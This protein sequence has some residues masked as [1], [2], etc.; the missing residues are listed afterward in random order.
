MALDKIKL[1]KCPPTCNQKHTCKPGLVYT[2][3]RLVPSSLLYNLHP[4]DQLLPE[5]LQNLRDNLNL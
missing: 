5:K 4:T 1:D 2:Y 3:P